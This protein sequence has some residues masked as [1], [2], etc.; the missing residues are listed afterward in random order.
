VVNYLLNRNATRVILLLKVPQP[1]ATNEFRPIACYDVV[2]KC[3]INLLYQRL[4]EGLSSLIC[5]NQ[6]V[7]VKGRQHVHNVLCVKN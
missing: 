3:I 1:K 5:S 4:T 2:C 7:F 6:Y